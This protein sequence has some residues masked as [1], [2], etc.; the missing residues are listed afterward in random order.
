MRGAMAS[1][2]RSARPIVLKLRKFIMKRWPTILLSALA[3]V[4][5]GYSGYLNIENQR[6]KQLLA[7]AADVEEAP[8]ALES[9]PEIEVAEESGDGEEETES[10]RG[11]FEGR[12]AEL[13]GLSREEIQERRREARSEQLARILSA[14]EDP[15]LR[16]DMIERQ[17][18]RLDRNYAEFF[19][20]L[21]LPPEELDALKTLMAERLVLRSEAGVRSQTVEGEDREAMREEY[22]DQM[23]LL[24]DDI[25]ALLGEEDAAALEKYTNTLEYRGEIESF[26]RSLSYTDTPLTERQSEALIDVFANVDQN[27][28]YSVDIRQNNG[29]GRGG[30][31]DTQITSEMVET[32]Y[33]EREIYDAMLLEQAA[34][35]L[36]DAQL[37]SLTEQ[38]V[39]ER[40]RELRQAQLALENQANSD[41][42]GFGRGGFGGFGGRGGGGFNGGRGGGGGR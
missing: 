12:F 41:G 26:E 1:R 13:E 16:M 42:P 39:A 28:E 6:L 24:S 25:T 19:K 7:D 33:Q 5:A 8:V 2:C 31:N 38:M 30:N 34:N 10:R 4:F 9:E 18:G 23:A 14:F 40:E 27:F 21:N 3:I 17:M 32:Y 11:R 37:A 22:R 35:V 36:N 15:E 20:Q 29:R